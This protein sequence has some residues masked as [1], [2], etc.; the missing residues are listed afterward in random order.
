MANLLLVDYEPELLDVIGELLRR[1]GHHVEECMSGLDAR[2]RIAGP[3]TL[4][5]AIIDWSLPD[6]GGRDLMRD[7]Q[8]RQPQARIII[9]TGH[10]ESVVSSN[11]TG[12]GVAAVLR[13]PFRMRDLLSLID[14]TLSSS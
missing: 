10:G 11:L 1:G 7:L 14:R 2:A 13:K 12:G 5:L 8:A 6:V 3:P 4:D 9:A